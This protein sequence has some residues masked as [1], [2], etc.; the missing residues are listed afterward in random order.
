MVVGICDKRHHAEVYDGEIHFHV[1]VNLPLGQSGI[2]EQGL[3]SF[4]H[5]LKDGLSIVAGNLLCRCIFFYLEIIFTLDKIG[6]AFVLVRYGIRNV[7]LV[8]HPVSFL[9]KTHT[10]HVLRI[11]RIVVNGCHGAELIEAFDQHAFRIEVCE[12]QRALYVS[13]STFFSPF[14]YRVDQGIG[15]FRVIN[16][17]NPAET[18][19]LF[20]PGFISLVVDYGSY[21]AHYFIVLVSQEILC[22]T[23]FKRRILLF[24]ESVEHVVVEI[25]NGVGV[26]FV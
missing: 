11:V 5:Q 9:L 2:T 17:I 4:V 19:I 25:G 20:I 6:D 22:F 14:F 13:H 23:E 21:A 8:F 10:L 16:E 3:I 7:D 24:I 15:Y 12:A 26:A 18:D 1:L